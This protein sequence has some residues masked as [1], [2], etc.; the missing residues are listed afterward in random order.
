MLI[1]GLY[2]HCDENKNQ[3]CSSGLCQA[4]VNFAYQQKRLEWN[5][6]LLERKFDRI[7]GILSMS[8]FEYRSINFCGFREAVSIAVDLKLNQIFGIK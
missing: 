4:A 1:V 3:S 6:F 5:K 7:D 8:D 2:H